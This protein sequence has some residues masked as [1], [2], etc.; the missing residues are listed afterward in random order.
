MYNIIH[1]GDH[2]QFS[3]SLLPM[4]VSKYTVSVYNIIHVGD[5][6][7]FSNSLLPMSVSKYTVSVYNII[8][9]D[10]SHRYS[11]TLSVDSDSVSICRTNI[12]A[13]K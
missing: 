7:Q 3:N 8:H 1:V 12:C 2:A 9:V 13:I 10:L 4:S 5:H 11:F 6:D